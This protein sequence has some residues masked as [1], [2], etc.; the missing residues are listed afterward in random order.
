MLKLKLPKHQAPKESVP[1]LHWQSNL[2][3]LNPSLKQVVKL[4]RSNPNSRDS[5]IVFHTG[6]YIVVSIHMM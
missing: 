2:V 3:L 4:Y 5:N 1:S 6:T